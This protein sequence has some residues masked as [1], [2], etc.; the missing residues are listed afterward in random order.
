VNYLYEFAW[1]SPYLGEDV[2]AAQGLDLPF[3][4]NDFENMQDVPRGRSI[5]GKTPSE[6]LAETMNTAFVD[7]VKTGEPGWGPWSPEER[8]S[9]RFSEECEV[10][11]GYQLM[12]EAVGGRR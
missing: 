8:E 1:R 10:E 11:Y 7:F 9:M 6:R 2:G 3:S 5:L 4:R 12:A